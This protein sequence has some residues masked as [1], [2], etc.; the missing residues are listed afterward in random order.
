MSTLKEDYN[1]IQ[2]L[3]FEKKA[4]AARLLKEVIQKAML[5]FHANTGCNIT[6]IDVEIISHYT[7]GQVYTSILSNIDIKSDVD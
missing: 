6:G 3:V 2:S 7:S 1:K 4:V 5:D